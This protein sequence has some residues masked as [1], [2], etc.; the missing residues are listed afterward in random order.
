M[1][2]G[3]AD[4]GAGRRHRDGPDQGGRRLHRPHRHRRRR[5]SPRRHGLQG[6]RHRGRASPPSR[7]TSRSPASRSTSCATRSSRPARAGSFIL[8]KMAEAIDGP[9]ERAL[10]STR[11]AIS[12]SRSTRRRSALLIGK[13][14]ETIRGLSRG[15]RGRR[16][17]STTTARSSSTR[18]TASWSRRCVERIRTM[19]KEVEVGDEFTGKVVKTTTFGAFVELVQGHRRPAA[20]L[21]RQARRAGRDRRGRAQPRRRDRRHRGRG[22]PRARPHRP[23]PH[24][25]PVDRRQVQ[26]GARL[27]RR[28][29]AATAAATAAPRRDR[30]ERNGGGGGGRGSGRPRHR[31]GDR[32]PDRG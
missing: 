28:P 14:G 1:A 2:R 27:R 16:S 25:R 30:G 9:R 29:P 15:V 10:A 11:R 19:T 4:Q 20:H 31:R 24:R 7:W 8:G 13:G 32:D 21:Q 6:R 18:R 26:R 3:R 23:A 22:R 17:T 5:G 12:R